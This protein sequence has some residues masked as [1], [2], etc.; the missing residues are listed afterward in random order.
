MRSIRKSV[1][2]TLFS[3]ISN[4][5]FWEYY[6]MHSNSLIVVNKYNIINILFQINAYGLDIYRHDINGVITA[7]YSNIIVLL[8][9]V[10]IIFFVF[11]RT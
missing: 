5:I 4:I 2:Q 6:L 10:P 7:L 9:Y 3:Q 11:F 8:N 1:S